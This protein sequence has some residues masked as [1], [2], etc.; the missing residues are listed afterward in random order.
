M[1]FPK[2]DAAR[3]E[4]I[5]AGELKPAVALLRGLPDAL[6]LP[7]NA[8]NLA[9][10]IVQQAIDE[11]VRQIAAAAEARYRASFKP[12]GYLLGTSDRPSQIFDFG[13]T[14][15][16]RKRFDRLSLKVETDRVVWGVVHDVSG[17]G[18]EKYCIW[19]SSDYGKRLFGEA[20]G[21]L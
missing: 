2:G 17:R 5:Y 19:R 13:I 9:P 15:G 18:T 21:R 20:F 1:V 4:Q 16:L 14:G 12:A 11:T 8:L 7:P 10:N 6:N 3:V